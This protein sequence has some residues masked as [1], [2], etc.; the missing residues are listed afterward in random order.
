MSVLYFNGQ[1]FAYPCVSTLAPPSLTSSS[2]EAPSAVHH[3]VRMSSRRL[4]L[5]I[6]VSLVEFLI[7]FMLYVAW[8]A[9]GGHRR[10]LHCMR[11]IACLPPRLVHSLLFLL[12]L[13]LLLLPPPCSLL[14][15]WLSDF[16]Y[17]YVSQLSLCVEYNSLTVDGFCKV[18]ISYQIQNP[19]N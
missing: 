16:S 12:L 4:P 7:M 1:W 13:L 15:P 11:A 10:L 3:V 6:F 8:S 2:L 19:F 18:K 5:I 9:F 14:N 17:F